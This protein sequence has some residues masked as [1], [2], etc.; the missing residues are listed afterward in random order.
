MNQ[1]L[2][3]NSDSIKKILFFLTGSFVF[4]LF[5]FFVV[6]PKLLLFIKWFV[7]SF[8]SFIGYFFIL[9]IFFK[10][11]KLIWFPIYSI[12]GKYSYIIL[13]LTFIY[14]MMEIF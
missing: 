6:F 3:E 2:K 13:F 9:W 7:P 1:K 12:F 11:L 8:W 14:I 5:F 4:I 10:I